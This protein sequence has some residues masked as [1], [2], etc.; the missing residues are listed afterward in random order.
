VS[1]WEIT[2]W[3]L[4]YLLVAVTAGVLIG[5]MI[6]HRDRHCPSRAEKRLTQLKDIARNRRHPPSP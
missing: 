6:A 3:A 4:V 2:G 5:K 1:W